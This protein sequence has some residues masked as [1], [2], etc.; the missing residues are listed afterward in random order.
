VNKEILQEL[1]KVVFQR[2][3]ELN[4]FDSRVIQQMEGM[5]IC[6]EMPSENNGHPFSKKIRDVNKIKLHLPEPHS[7]HYSSEW[8]TEFFPFYEV[9]H[10]IVGHKYF[11]ISG[12]AAKTLLPQLQSTTEKLKQLN[13]ME[14]YHWITEEVNKHNPIAAIIW[15]NYENIIEDIERKLLEVPIQPMVSGVSIGVLP[16]DFLTNLGKELENAA[17]SIRAV[18]EDRANFMTYLVAA[19]SG[20]ENW[21]T[22]R[23]LQ[24]IAMG[25]TD[26]CIPFFDIWYMNTDKQ[27]AVHRLANFDFSIRETKE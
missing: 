9:A 17:E 20:G 15:K 2:M 16:T 22:V 23:D 8:I 13:P 10:M 27:E 19:N 5:E 3:Y 12:P 21:R 25:N 26:D 18:N 6:E 1:G 4:W 7:F 11:D 14:S 24:V